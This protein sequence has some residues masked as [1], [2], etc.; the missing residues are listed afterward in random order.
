MATSPW[1]NGS[2]K[3]RLTESPIILTFGM[4]QKVCMSFIILNILIPKTCTNM[5]SYLEHWGIKVVVTW[6]LDWYVKFFTGLWKKLLGLS[7][8]FPLV[9][10]W[11]KSIRSHLYWC[12]LSSD[13]N[14]EVMVAKWKSMVNHIANVHE[15]DDVEFPTCAHGKIHKEWFNQGM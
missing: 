2:G 10:R 5:V 6:Y 1:E 8:T 13:G 12:A 14:A 11:M 3:K 4:C 9:G 15:H 7:K